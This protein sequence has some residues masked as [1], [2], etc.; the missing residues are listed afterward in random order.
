MRCPLVLIALAIGCGPKIVNDRPVADLSKHLPAT[1]EASRPREGDAKTIHVRIWADAGV[2]A[3]PKW[4]EEIIDQADYASQLLAPL[5]GVRIAIDKISDWNRT[6]EPSAAA[7]ALAEQDK[8]KDATWVIGYIA[9]NDVSTKVMSELGNAEPLGKYIIVRGYAEQPETKVLTQTLP[10]LKGPERSEIVS[11]HRRHKQTVVLLHM[12]AA[13]LGAIE[14]QDPTW[15]QNPTYKSKQVGFS[16]RNRE[17]LQIAID[18]KLADQNDQTIA[19]KLLE[20]I[21]KSEFGG[22]TPASK[23]EVT[24]R[25]RIAI[26]AGKGSRTAKAIPPAAYDQFSRIQTL[27]RQGNTKDALAEL[28]NLLIAYPGNAAMHQARCEIMLSIGG[29]SAI[30]RAKQPKPAPKAPPAPKQEPP[31]QVDW[32]AACARAVEYAAGDPTPH[33]LVAVSYFQAKDIKAARAELLLAEGKIGNLPPAEISD[34]WKKVIAMYTEIG[35]LSWTDEAVTKGKLD[36]DPAA[37]KVAQTR[38][39]YG[40]PQGAKFVAPEQE[41]ELVAVIKD[42]LQLVYANKFGQ[43]EGMLAAAERKWSGAPGIAST[44]CDLAL[45]Q[46]QLDAARAHCARALAA[47]P[48]NSWAL[49]LTGVIALKPGSDAATRQGIDQLK[50]AIAVD[51][52]LQQAWRTLA[53]AYIRTKDKAAYEQLGKDYQAKF[54]SPLPL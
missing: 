38:A 29:P 44:R 16:D 33:L 43:A 52:D 15:I 48:T 13:A 31:P 26:D 53:K 27:A 19:K 18:E 46:N 36:S 42:A 5:L 34:A 2:R 50:K 8:G 11:A 39:R 49:Y 21:E 54:G 9:P 14:E 30:A 24:K 12:I 6:G 51:P 47:Q 40:I 41:A 7:T 4:R 22:W 10:D 17:L 20:A 1:L 23:D 32:K 28:D 35:A 45:R 3:Q 25:L 37:L